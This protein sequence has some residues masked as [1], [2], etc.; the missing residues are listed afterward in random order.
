[1]QVRVV[2]DIGKVWDA[3]SRAFR[4]AFGD[5]SPHLVDNLG[6][7]RL[8][9]RRGAMRVVDFNPHSVARPAIAGL[10]KW[11]GDQEQSCGRLCLAYGPA[12]SAR[13]HRIF[14]SGLAALHELEALIEEVRGPQLPFI[15]L[16]EALKEL[17]RVPAL[18]AVFSHWRAR[19]GVFED[20]EYRQ[21]L[22]Q[23]ARD[24]FIII[25]PRSGDGALKIVHAGHGLQIPDKRSHAAL[26][27]AQLTEFGDE[28][29]GR[30]TSG[31]YRGVLER[32]VPRC[33][34]I[35]AMIH[36][37]SVGR[38][39]RKYSRLILPCRTKEGQQLLL[40]VSGELGAPDLDVGVA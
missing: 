7:I 33:D 2:D 26:N 12:G 36:W 31:I 30:W 9:L 17:Y 5:M 13:T 34:H 37:P 3:D 35:Y 38:V 25:A 29:Y 18:A 20:T 39:E 8:L 22:N 10:I 14:G 16:P 1:M 19:S 23:H 32:Q 24:R 15:S 27:G 21:L 40:G 28:A 11:L 6:F 4:D